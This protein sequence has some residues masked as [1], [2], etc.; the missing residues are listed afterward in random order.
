[1]D[2]R[3]WI[4]DRGSKMPPLQRG[5]WAARPCLHVAGTSCPRPSMERPAP[6]FEQPKNSLPLI[7]L[8]P[9]RGLPSFA[10]LKCRGAE[11]AEDYA[12]RIGGIWTR[13][14]LQ[15]QFDK[16]LIINALNSVDVRVKMT[17]NQK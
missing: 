16:S 3:S 7:W 6:C 17:E 9:S 15:R 10:K 1:M 11:F 2:R 14:I 12:E 13:A 8:L 4:V 5:A